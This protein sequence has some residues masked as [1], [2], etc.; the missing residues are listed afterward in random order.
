VSRYRSLLVFMPLLGALLNCNT[1]M[2][3]LQPATPTVV[4]PDPPTATPAPTSTDGPPSDPTS[5]PV[6]VD[7]YDYLP[8]PTYVDAQWAVAM[9]WYSAQELAP[10]ATGA[11]DWQ[12]GDVLAFKYYNAAGDEIEVKAELRHI[13]PHFYM[14]FEEGTTASDA[15]I[16]AAA[17]RIE[18]EIYPTSR[19]VFGEEWSPGVDGD[20]HI[21]ILNMAELGDSYGEFS[22]DDECP[23]ALC[24][25]SNGHEMIYIGLEDLRVGTNEYLAVVAHELQ[26]L[27]GYNTD[28]SESGWVGEGLS[29]LSEL[30]NGYPELASGPVVDFFDDPDLQLNQWPAPDEDDWPNYGASYLF[31]LYLYE[32][33]GE[34]FI[35]DWT[36]QPHDDMTG[37]E[38]TLAAHTGLSLNQVFG[39]WAVANL[40]DDTQVE[41][42]QFGYRQEDV[43][44]IDFTKTHTSYPVSESATVHQFAADYVRFNADQDLHIIFQGD[45]RV[46]LLP[47]A[48]HSGSRF[49][50]SNRLEAS[51]ASLQTELDLSGLSN[52]TARFWT[53]FDTEPDYDVVMVQVSD[54]QGQSWTIVDGRHSQS[55]QWWE[56]IYTGTSGSGGSP[57]WVE[58]E[59]DLRRWAGE[60]IVLRIQ[61]ITDPSFNRAGLA[62]DDFVLDS[63]QGVQRQDDFESGAPGWEALG[64]VH[65]NADVRQSWSVHLVT[66][67]G[68]PVIHPLALDGDNRGAIDVAASGER[69]QAI[70]VVAA[71]APF[72]REWANY[73]YEVSALP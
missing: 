59:I 62:L 54:D 19:R 45:T 15:N 33:F 38:A 17:E 65:A 50:W 42:G 10:P 22:S 39:E 29:V 48:A 16:A 34:P 40:V 70:L 1:V 12:T 37:V 27:I 31:A 24:D 49:W 60:S 11:L 28:G 13:T 36:R 53:W 43:P 35:H 51:A 7:S 61:Y 26:H 21:I 4:Q 18:N 69:L 72:S 6:L 64:F 58:E 25:Y 55:D 73:R 41:G 63:D 32:R 3:R 30:I 20:P 14:I 8:A 2:S 47:A 9:G 66:L 5:L 68:E 52:P 46:P 23:L 57:E 56:H 44:A 67:E 71:T